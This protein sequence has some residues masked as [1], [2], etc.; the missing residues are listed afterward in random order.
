MTHAASRGGPSAGYRDRPARCQKHLCAQGAGPPF[1][2]QLISRLPYPCRSRRQGGVV[3]DGAPSVR[4]SPRD[5]VFARSIAN[6]ISTV[7]LGPVATRRRRFILPSLRDSGNFKCAFSRHSR[8]GLG[9]AA[10]F[11]F[12]QGR[13][14]GA[15][16]SESIC[17]ENKR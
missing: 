13:L 8:A 11:D 10:P 6:S 15:A 2:P 5:L 17:C 12:A 7:P 4:S 3:P 1:P 14:C 9:S 16:V